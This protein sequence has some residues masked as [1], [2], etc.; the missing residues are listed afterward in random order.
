MS[1]EY[2]TSK[3]PRSS[4]AQCWWNTRFGSITNFG[5]MLLG[6]IDFRIATHLC[7]ENKR[8]ITQ[9]KVYVKWAQL[10]FFLVHTEDKTFILKPAYH[11][12]A[13]VKL[14]Y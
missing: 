6:R 11:S 1:I 14:L 3:C 12:I 4:G 13:E 5:R 2:D 8:N 7:C 10:P 9:R